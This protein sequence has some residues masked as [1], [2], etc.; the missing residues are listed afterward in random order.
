MKYSG[1]ESTR[2]TF[3]I[4]TLEEKGTLYDCLMMKVN[5]YDSLS[6]CKCRHQNRPCL[7]G[8]AT[9]VCEIYF[10]LKFW[11]NLAL[12]DAKKLVSRKAINQIKIAYYCN[13]NLE[14]IGY[15]L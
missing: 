6:Y 4:L 3:N 15:I 9:S 7:K 2:Q 11:K 8:T 12:A 10:S 13:D 5:D 1:S 14:H